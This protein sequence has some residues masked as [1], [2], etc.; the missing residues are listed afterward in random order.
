DTPKTTPPANNTP[1]TYVAPTPPA[2]DTPKTTPPANN[3]PATVYVPAGPSCST[4]PANNTPKTTPPANNT[5]A[6]YVAPIPSAVSTPP[7]N[8]TPA[9]T[10]YVPPV[11]ANTYKAVT[12]N[13]YSGAQ[14]AVVG[15]AA[16][17][18]AALFAF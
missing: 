6:T 13:L 7:A 3:T 9:P 12:N 1:A 16:A 15:L 4:P 8:N 5:P 18:A 10:A 14:T 17:I 2:K 11:V